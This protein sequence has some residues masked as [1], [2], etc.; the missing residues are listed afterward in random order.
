MQKNLKHITLIADS[1]HKNELKEITTSLTKF[2]L[3]KFKI[4]GNGANIP[5]SFLTTFTLLQEIILSFDDTC[6]LDFN[7][8]QYVTFPQLHILKFQYACPKVEMLIKFLEIN[9]KHLT[10]L[11]VGCHK[12]SLS[13]AVV[14]FC[15][16]LKKLHLIFLNNELEALKGIFNGCQYLESIK[17]K[18]GAGYFGGNEMLEMVSKYSPKNFYELRIDN[19][20]SELSSEELES[21]FISWR[22]RI[23]QQSLSFIIFTFDFDDF[24]EKIN[25]SLYIDLRIIEKYK[26]LGVIKKFETE[27]FYEV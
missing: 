3:T 23:P 24:D 2:T 12:N 25:L 7:Q 8:L 13:S 5:L 26:T 6:V 4:F 15:P 19:T 1:G 17:I 11:Y 21:F 9:G 10:E 18:C 22:D 27:K 20:E 14:K 16:N